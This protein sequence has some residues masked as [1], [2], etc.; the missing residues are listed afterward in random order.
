MD[1][2]SVVVAGGGVAAIEAL[3]R[4]RRLAGDALSLTLLAPNDRFALRALSVKEP[5]AMG[6]AERH[7]VGRIARDAEAEWVRDTLAWVDPDAQ[8]AHAADGRELPYDALLIAVGARLAPAFDH[9]TTFRDDR[10]DE[11]VGGIVRDVEDGYA[12]RLAFL[13]PGGPA[14]PLPLYELALMSAERAASSGSADFEAVLVTSEPRPLSGFGEVASAAAAELLERSGVTVHAASSAEVPAAGQVHVRPAD[15]D[16]A[17]DRVVA[18]PRMSGPAIRGLPGAGAHGFVPVD[19]HCAVR[20]AGGR[21]FAAGDATDSPIKHGGLGAQ[22]ADQA[23]AAIAGLAGVDVDLP[24]FH[25][26]IRGTLLTGREPLYMQAHLVGGGSFES[27]VSDA[28]L[29][30]PGDKVVADELGAYLRRG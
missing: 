18:L 16:L 28:P 10:A 1:R 15:V 2:F 6:A 17:A 4:L 27:E 22:Q 14:W 12:K 23:A 26:V 29:W 9:A 13:A 8:V 7:D 20:A 24:P 3:L 25:P 19:E 5:F 11:L 30:E 21:V